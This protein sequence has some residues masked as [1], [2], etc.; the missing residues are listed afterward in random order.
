MISSLADHASKPKSPSPFVAPEH[1]HKSLQNKGLKLLLL[2]N[3][4][5]SQ[6]Y[7]LQ[8]CRGRLGQSSQD[9]PTLLCLPSLIPSFPPSQW[10]VCLPLSAHKQPHCPCSLLSEDLSPAALDSVCCSKYEWWDTSKFVGWFQRAQP[11]TPAAAPLQYMLTL[12]LGTAVLC[13]CNHCGSAF[14]AI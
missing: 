5:H 4:R 10:L 12:A 1:T 2:W 7:R 14:Q 6:G 9:P 13:I 3:K 8:V 11:E